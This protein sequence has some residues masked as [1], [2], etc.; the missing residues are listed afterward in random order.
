MLFFYFGFFFSLRRVVARVWRWCSFGLVIFTIVVMIIPSNIQSTELL[1][2]CCCCCLFF[3]YTPCR[4]DS[5][6]LSEANFSTTIYYYMLKRSSWP[7]RN[8]LSNYSL[9][10][11]LS[12]F[13][14]MQIV[15]FHTNFIVVIELVIYII[16]FRSVKFAR[17]RSRPRTC[18]VISFIA[19]EAF[20][21]WY[22]LVLLKCTTVS[23]IFNPFINDDLSGNDRN[24]EIWMAWKCF[25]MTEFMLNVEI[26]TSASWHFLL[27]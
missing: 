24:T 22:Y 5:V 1:C 9:S 26:S 8:K 4:L 15:Y 10:V 27:P 18:N 11:S 25:A 21:A 20:S 14:L 7:Q 17:A 16:F 3:R 23:I 2:V 19:A 13:A 6:H 12:F